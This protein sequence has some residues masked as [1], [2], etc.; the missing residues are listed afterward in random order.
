MPVSFT[1]NYD[2]VRF[3]AYRRSVVFLNKGTEVMCSANNVTFDYAMKILKESHIRFTIDHLEK[4]KKSVNEIS[5]TL[6]ELLKL[7]EKGGKNL[8][9]TQYQLRRLEKV[10]EDFERD[11]TTLMKEG[12]RLASESA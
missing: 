4:V 5:E 12:R 3:D 9:D 10:L 2:D 6:D 11:G 1:F 8:V 7:H